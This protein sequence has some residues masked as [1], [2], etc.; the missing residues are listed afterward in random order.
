MGTKL[1]IALA[2][3]AT[4]M[5]GLPVAVAAAQD[6]EIN[7]RSG[8]ERFWN[9]RGWSTIAYKTVG[10]GTDTDR[11]YAPGKQRYTNL[12]L[13]SLEAPIRMRDFDVYFANGQRQDVRTR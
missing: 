7:A 10:S 13:C 11:I 8:D 12:R 9:Y 2:M 5:V 6:I 1:K 3:T 4:L